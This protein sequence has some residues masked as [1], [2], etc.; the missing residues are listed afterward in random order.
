MASHPESPTPKRARH[1]KTR[2]SKPPTLRRRHAMRTSVEALA[3]GCR[4]SRRCQ[5]REYRSRVPAAEKLPCERS[6][7]RCRERTEPK[8][9]AVLRAI[10]DSE[11][12]AEV[13]RFLESLR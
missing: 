10:S 3:G 12:D 13:D 4:P 9:R 8:P 2:R 5:G 6:D 7:R 11:L 1:L